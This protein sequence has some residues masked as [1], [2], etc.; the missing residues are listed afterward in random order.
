LQNRRAF[1]VLILAIVLGAGAA[2]T[3]KR[4]LEEQ[5]VLRPGP[6]AE[7]A[8]PIT[9]VRS[10]VA[11]GSALS[12]GDLITV[13]W[14]VEFAPEGAFSSPE[15]VAGRVLRRPLAG[16]EPVLESALL[17]E[18]ARGGLVSVIDPSRRAVSVKVDP[19]VGVA[20]FVVPGSHVDVLAT[21]R[22]QGGG[23]SGSSSQA[24]SK[25][26]L[27]DVQVLA[28]DQRLEEAKGSSR[29][30]LVQ[31][32]TLEVSPEQAEKLTFVAHEGKLQLAL[33]NPDDREIVV[34]QSVGA[35]EVLDVKPPPPPKARPRVA[36][37]PKTNVEV[38]KG[39][40]VSVETF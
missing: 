9:V 32:V 15:E 26:V 31:V 23:A 19:V 30:E 39:A 20:G 33:R 35:N 13:D 12:E 22:R 38:I 1:F 17:P 5:L 34:T 28:I 2:L 7:K 11:V 4:W 6:E 18:G 3:A 21:L 27:Q 10:D 25:V 29:P 8:R 40:Q 16:G 37:A 14:P 24:V 36:A